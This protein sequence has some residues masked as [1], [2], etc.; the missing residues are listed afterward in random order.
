MVKALFSEDKSIYGNPWRADQWN[1]TTQ[2]AFVAR[3]GEAKAAEFAKAA[4]TSIGALKPKPI[5]ERDVLVKNFIL[6][7]KVGGAGGT[8]SSGSGPPS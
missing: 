1:L 5:S 4:G 8:G 2:G 7:K 3:Y 6:I